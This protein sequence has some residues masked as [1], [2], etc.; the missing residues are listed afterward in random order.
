MRPS[1]YRREW[2]ADGTIP[3]IP[4]SPA[5]R[6]SLHIGSRGGAPGQDGRL[7][8]PRAPAV[9]GYLSVCPLSLLCLPPLWAPNPPTF[10]GLS[11]LGPGRRRRTASHGRS[12][13]H[14]DL[15]ASPAPVLEITV[16]RG[17]SKWE[18]GRDRSSPPSGL[19]VSGSLRCL[20]H[21]VSGIVV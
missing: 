11:P 19:D 3:D 12:R 9:P 17:P 8:A 13:A 14:P 6:P 21:W 5:P 7:G 16:T 20:P 15:S 2:R 18:V 1:P 10:R 4:P